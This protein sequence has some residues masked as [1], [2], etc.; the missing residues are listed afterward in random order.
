M[1]YSYFIHAILTLGKEGRGE[2]E[3][4]TVIHKE[5]PSDKGRVLC[6]HKEYYIIFSSA[7]LSGQ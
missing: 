3:C 7:C 4:K 2:G 5:S 1:K 6:Y